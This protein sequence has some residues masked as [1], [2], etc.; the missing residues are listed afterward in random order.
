MQFFF[1]LFTGAY[2]NVGFEMSVELTFPSSESTA[3]GLLLC[4]MQI[5]A[6]GLT[7]VVGWVNVQYGCFWAIFS[8]VVVLV[9]GNV[10]TCLT[11]NKL[12]RQAAFREGEK[13]LDVDYKTVA[14]IE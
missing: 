9:V 11:P 5:L 6:A 2:A 4:V 3:S 10:I 14:N 8:L 7:V 1:R 13:H 12:R